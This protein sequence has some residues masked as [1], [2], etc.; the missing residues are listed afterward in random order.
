MICQYF[1]R[2]DAMDLKKAYVDFEKC[3]VS[4]DRPSLRLNQF[5]AQP[6]FRAFPFSMLLKQQHTEQ[7]PVHHPEGN[8]WSHTLLVVDEAAKRK[9]YAENSN[10]F[11]WAALLHD[12][13]KPQTTK[14]RKGKITAYNHDRAGAK[15]ASEFLCVF[16]NKTAFIE[17]VV[18]LV[19]YHMQILYAVKSLPFSDLAGIKKHANVQDVALLGY[20]DRLGR[21]GADS[22]DAR[23]AVS[24]FL[25]KCGEATNPVWLD[26][27]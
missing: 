21:T 22:A 4:D 23:N 2:D 25:Q 8:V 27:E 18:W 26:A 9:L 7:S 12:I 15:L 16:T 10:V 20:C 14:L 19:Q 24:V 13:G 1:N 11:M 5:A 3:V 17:K 6:W